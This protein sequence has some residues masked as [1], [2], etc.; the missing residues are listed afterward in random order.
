[1]KQIIIFLLALTITACASR[2]K[3]VEKISSLHESAVEIDSAGNTR[4]Q[5]TS[6]KATQEI[7]KQVNKKSEI[8]FE[9]KAGDSLQIAE[10]GSDGKLISKTVI[11]G[12]GK[13][14]IKKDESLHDVARNDTTA[15]LRSSAGAAKVK[16]KNNQKNSDE[17][18]RKKVESS[19]MS[20]GFW[21]WLLVLAIVAIILWYLNKRFKWIGWA[22]Q[23]TMS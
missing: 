6:T 8:L 5:E 15:L 16:K 4:L 3:D 14:A 20:F 19:G 9:G 11:T 7:E 12:T 23:K 1:M 13:A 22:V 21:I 2:R 10:Y 18:F 17:A